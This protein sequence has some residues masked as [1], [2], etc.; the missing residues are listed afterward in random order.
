MSAPEYVAG[1]PP[2]ACPD[3]GENYQRLS[4]HWAMSSECSPPPLSDE[5][6]AALAGLRL[7]GAETYGASDSVR[8]K[9]RVVTASRPRAI[10]WHEQLGW[11]SAGVRVDRADREE[12]EDTVQLTTHAHHDLSRLDWELPP[13]ELSLTP[14]MARAWLSHSGGISFGSGSDSPRLSWGHEDA[15][16]RERVAGLLRAAGFDARVTDDRVL[17]TVESTHA[18][19]EYAGEPV[20]G[21]EH[22]WAATREEYERLIDSQ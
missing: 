17:L 3:C 2:Y 22:K 16:W 1:G 18:F 7:A 8:P 11:L 12:R 4:Q 21:A 14:L 6:M 20:P 19:Q 15:A 9:F 10:W 13:S 5:Q